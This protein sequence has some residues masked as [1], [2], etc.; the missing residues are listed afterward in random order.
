VDH[1]TGKKSV[2]YTT[3][4]IADPVLPSFAQIKPPAKLVTTQNPQFVAKTQQILPSVTVENPDY[5]EVVGNTLYP[6]VE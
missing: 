3:T 1:N 5:K 4:V 2:V 6:F